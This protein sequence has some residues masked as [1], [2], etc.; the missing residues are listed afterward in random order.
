MRQWISGSIPKYTDI[1]Y[2]IALKGGTTNNTYPLPCKY[3][4]EKGYWIDAENTQLS[5]KTIVAYYPI[6]MPEPYSVIG[7]GYYVRTWHEDDEFIYG[8]G[9]RFANWTGNGYPTKEKAISA[10]KRKKKI[11]QSENNEGDEYEV[12]DGNGEVVWSLNK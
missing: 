3:D 2:W 1:F 9:L 11:D 6:R 8:F 7:T 4:T 12:L 10:T 5:S